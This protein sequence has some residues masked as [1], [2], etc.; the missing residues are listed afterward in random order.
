VVKFGSASPTRKLTSCPAP[1]NNILLHPCYR[2]NGKC[3]HMSYWVPHR[4]RQLSSVP[5]CCSDEMKT[6]IEMKIRRINNWTEDC[7]TVN[8]NRSFLCVSE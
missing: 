4:S 3:F 7:I 8:I 6:G 1:V 5:R 2:L